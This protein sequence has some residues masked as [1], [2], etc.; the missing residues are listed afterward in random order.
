[1]HADMNEIIKDLRLGLDVMSAMTNS[2]NHLAG[3]QGD[4]DSI[5]EKFVQHGRR[6][7]L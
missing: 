4:L 2:V 7:D 1:M 3:N 5:V 6:V